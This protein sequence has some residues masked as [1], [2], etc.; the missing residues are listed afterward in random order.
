MT[1]DVDKSPKR[2]QSLFNTIA[3]R[4]DLLNHLLSFGM[5]RYWRRQTVRRLDPRVDGPIL[6]L[7]TGTADFAVAYAKKHPTRHVVGLDFSEKMLEI[8]KQRVVRAKLG[9]RID[10]I[11]GDALSLPFADRSFALVSVSY[12]LRNMADTRRGLSEMVRVCKPGGTVAVLEFCMPQR[13]WFAPVYR[14]YFKNVMPRWG[15][16]VSGET[17]GAYRHLL[18]SVQ[19]FPQGDALVELMRQAGIAKINRFPMTFGTIALTFGEIGKE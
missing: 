16:W 18:E 19:T 11:E 8:G 12:G 13:G 10:L 9:S 6:D 17:V 7:C 5:D 4:Y 1:T 15:A 2:I 14:W 3:P